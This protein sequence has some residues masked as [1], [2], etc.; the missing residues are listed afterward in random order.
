M[1]RSIKF[2]A[3]A[4]PRFTEPKDRAYLALFGT[5]LHQQRMEEARVKTA[6]FAL[7]ELKDMGAGTPLLPDF[8]G[9]SRPALW[10]STFD[11]AITWEQQM[12]IEHISQLSKDLG[13]HSSVKLLPSSE[14]GILMDIVMPQREKVY[15]MREGRR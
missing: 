7:D 13:Y 12:T 2:Q 8:S 4:Q 1:S 14:G 10:E 3:Q 11:P 15:V 6:P 5:S 9:R